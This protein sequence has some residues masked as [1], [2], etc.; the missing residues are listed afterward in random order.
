MLPKHMPISVDARI[1][2]SIKRFAAFEGIS[3]SRFIG[4]VLWSGYMKKGALSKVHQGIFDLW[5]D[6]ALQFR[7]CYNPAENGD[8]ESH[9]EFIK[10][11]VQDRN[12][13]LVKNAGPGLSLSFAQICIQIGLA[14]DEAGVKKLAFRTT[15]AVSRAL[16]SDGWKRER[17]HEKGKGSARY[18]RKYT[19]WVWNGYEDDFDLDEE[20]KGA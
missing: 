8:R 4:A 19:V 7:N 14:S 11:E 2:A 20:A 18:A 17:R 13:L 3:M 12:D 16:L 9:E 15:G 5:C 6:N 10:M 1:H